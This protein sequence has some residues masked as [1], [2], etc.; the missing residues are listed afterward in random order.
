MKIDKRIVLI[1]VLV[2]CLPAW[3]Q[4]GLTAGEIVVGSCSAL[5]GPA[6]ALGTETILGARA[7]FNLVN[8]HGGVNGRKLRLVSYDDSYEPEKT[9]A[10][11][12]KLLQEDDV[13]S[14]G[15][16]VGTPTGAK[17][18]PMAETHKVPIVGFF[19][20]A[21]L[22]RTPVKHYVVNVRASYYNEARTM[23]DNLVP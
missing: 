23:V 18:A 13:F 14:L 19:T 11:V 9:I 4:K 2:L 20:G 15:F 12:N 17:A 7:Y 22:L 5:Q 6:S 3:S 21:E 16:F 1:L 8:E 10:C